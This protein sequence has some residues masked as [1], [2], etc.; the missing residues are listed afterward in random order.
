MAHYP[1]HKIVMT[2]SMKLPIYGKFGKARMTKEELLA[3]FAELI[4]AGDLQ[5]ITGARVVGIDGGDGDLIVRTAGGTDHRARK[6]ILATGRRGTPKRLGVPGESL[7]KVTY[8]LTD[9]EQYSGRRVLVVG[10]GD[11]ALE[12][13]AMLAEQGDV[14]VT[15][16]YRGPT[17]VRSRVVNQDRAHALIAAGRLR[18]VFQAEVRAIGED[19]VV[20]ATPE[21]EVRLANDYVIVS[22]GGQLP[23]ELL[24]ALQVGVKRHFGSVARAHPVAGGAMRPTH[25]ARQ[26]RLFG[27]ALFAIGAFVVGGI[28]WLGRDYYLLSAAERLRS[29][30]H[31]DLRSSGA[32]GYAIGLMATVTM[33]STFVYSLRKRWRRL[34]GTAPIRTWLTF[35]VFAGVLTPFLVAFH[36]VFRAQN[37]VAAATVLAMGA[38]LAT[39]LVGRFIYGLV[40]SA[41]G[42]RQETAKKVLSW[43]RVIHVVMAVFL[44]VA[45]AAHVGVAVYLGYGFGA[46]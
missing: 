25:A 40:P 44:V 17:F 14:D 13:A 24:T 46:R 32:V 42:A 7:E 27:A 1:R 9:P 11:S 4:E 45:V 8:R 43:W 10:G 5:V 22:I 39:G 2:E 33:A 20:F 12:A 38:V 31:G 36:A 3:R 6:V 37:E 23:V 29:P 15:I 21:G 35:H 41:A 18:G 19:H 28:A 34:K 30:L 26:R 16:A